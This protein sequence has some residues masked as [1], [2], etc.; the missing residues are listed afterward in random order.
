MQLEPA[1]AGR[2]LKPASQLETG[3]FS[4]FRLSELQHFSLRRDLLVATATD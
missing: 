2:R 3:E 4:R 1:D